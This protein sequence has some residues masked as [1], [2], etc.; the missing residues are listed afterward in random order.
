MSLMKGP[1]MKAVDFCIYIEATLDHFY[2]VQYLKTV[3]SG[4]LAASLGFLE[5][6][7]WFPWHC[8]W[9]FHGQHHNRPGGHGEAHVCPILGGPVS[10][11]RQGHL[12]PED[13]PQLGNPILSRR[14]QILLRNFIYDFPV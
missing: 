10:F 14:V 8:D 13:D 4:L 12:M 2:T 1:L 3:G 9:G 7:L 5:G 11:G 6:Q